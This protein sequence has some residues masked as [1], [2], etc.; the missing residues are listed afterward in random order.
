MDYRRASR[1]AEWTLAAAVVLLHLAIFLWPEAGGQPQFLIQAAHDAQLLSGIV[2]IVGW[3][4]LGPGSPWLRGGA[5]PVLAILWFLPW[6]ERIMP[7]ETTA[8]FQFTLAI[9]AAAVIVLLRLLGFRMQRV[10]PAAG[11]ERSAQFSLFGLLIATTLIAAAIGGLEALRPAMTQDRSPDFLFVLGELPRRPQQVREIVLAAAVALSAI[12]GLWVVAR[13]GA[14]WFRLGGIALA[15]PVAAVYLAYM[16]GEAD[17]RTSVAVNLGLGLALVAGLTGL[18]VLPLR[19]LDFRLKRPAAAGARSVAAA[20]KLGQLASRGAAIAVVVALVGLLPF[21][22]PLTRSLM[23]GLSPPATA[24]AAWIQPRDRLALQK[25]YRLRVVQSLRL[26]SIRLG[27]ELK[28]PAS[29]LPPRPLEIP[30]FREIDGWEYRTY[31]GPLMDGRSIIRS[32]GED[33]P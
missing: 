19:M 24:F 25:S 3:C 27:F 16:T 1:I 18:S 8:A 10:D 6:N 9:T 26:R 32:T 4:I 12:G 11:P 23:G 20:P 5:L 15:L 2:L 33:E 14:A 17:Q 7:R 22:K 21:S 13:P 29:P 30:S 28:Q 31:S